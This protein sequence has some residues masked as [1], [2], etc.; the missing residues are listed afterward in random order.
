MEKKIRDYRKGVAGL[1]GGNTKKKATQ[2]EGRLAK[3]GALYSV[4]W[5]GWQR[6][7]EPKVT[8][9]SA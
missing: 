4:S 9:Y 3:V 2:T 5:E 6:K 8:Q 7:R 1:T